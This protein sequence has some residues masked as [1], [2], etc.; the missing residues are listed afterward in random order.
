LISTISKLIFF[1]S[2]IGIEYLATTSVVIKPVTDNWDKANHFTAFFVLYL[3]LSF[4]Y[5]DLKESF[6]I[7]V[8]LFFGIQIEIVQYFLPSREFSLLD[9]FADSIGIAVAFLIFKTFV[10]LK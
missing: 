8:L 1:A 2:I 5:R 6:K 10:K 9:V 3:A 7:C 4:G